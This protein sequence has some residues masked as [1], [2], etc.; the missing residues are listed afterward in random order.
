MGN[1]RQ[2]M[3]VGLSCLLDFGSFVLKGEPLAGG[4]A[5]SRAA[6]TENTQAAEPTLQA[7]TATTRR[8]IQIARPAY[9]ACRSYSTKL[10]AATTATRIRG[11]PEPSQ[12]STS[13]SQEHE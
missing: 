1:A 3:S 5:S 12:A 8:Q 10:Y 9:S 2:H 13:P 6:D 4:S 7:R 11:H